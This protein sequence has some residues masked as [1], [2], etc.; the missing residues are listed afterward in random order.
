MGR[1]T[2][3]LRDLNTKLSSLNQEVYVEAANKLTKWLF[4]DKA[5]YQEVRPQVSPLS[6]H[7]TSHLNVVRPAT[8]LDSHN[9]RSVFYLIGTTAVLTIVLPDGSVHPC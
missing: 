9:T 8:R 4:S 1:N 3:I 7:M 5:Y 2:R 6:R